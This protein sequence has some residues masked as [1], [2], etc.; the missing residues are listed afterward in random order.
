MAMEVSKKDLTL[1]RGALRTTFIRSEYKRGF[2]DTIEI[3]EYKTKKD[4]TLYS[5]PTRY[6]IC[7]NCEGKHLLKDCKVDHIKP[8]GQYFDFAHT[9]GFIER[10]WCDYDNLQGLCDS[11]H[12]DKTKYERSLIKGYAK[13]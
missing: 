5:K 8:I 11:C 3:V 2:L 6:F 4:G 9:E 7:A 12:K 1:I 10:L 13:L